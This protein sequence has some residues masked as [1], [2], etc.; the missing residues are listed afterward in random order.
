LSFQNNRRAEGHLLAKIENEDPPVLAMI[1]LVGVGK[2]ST[3]NALFNSGLEISHTRPCTKFPQ[4]VQGNLLEHTGANGKVIVY[5]MPGLGETLQ[6]D[7]AYYQS[8]VNVLPIVDAAIWV[9]DAPN[10][11]MTPIQ[12]AIFRLQKECGNDIVDKIVFAANKIDRVYPGEQSWNTMANYPGQEQI[13]YIKDYEAYL[14]S[15]IKSTIPNY[16]K[17]IIGYSATRY[18]CLPMLFNELGGRMGKREWVLAKNA[19]V[20]NQQDQMAI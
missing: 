12:S 7:E 8:Y 11:M 6:A 15:I 18:Y 14:L 10:R 13:P 1:G 4:P 19:S 20:A 9:I 2:T 3:I 5:D 16:N 17:R